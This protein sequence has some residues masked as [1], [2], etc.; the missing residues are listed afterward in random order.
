MK[1]SLAFISSHKYAREKICAW[2]FVL[3]GDAYFSVD[4]RRRRWRRTRR[5]NIFSHSLRY[6]LS[7]TH[8]P[9]THIGCTFYSVILQLWTGK[10]ARAC[11]TTAFWIRIESNWK[12]YRRERKKTLYRL[13]TVYALGEV[14]KWRNGFLLS[15]G[16]SFVCFSLM[17]LLRMKKPHCQIIWPW[18]TSLPL[19]NGNDKYGTAWHGIQCSRKK[20]PQPLRNK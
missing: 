18:H 2:M 9:I 20:H 11:A 6:K 1:L 14:Q 12:G 13:R 16:R 19:P 7:A 4:V 3:H 15:L 5:F 17:T 8:K 10:W